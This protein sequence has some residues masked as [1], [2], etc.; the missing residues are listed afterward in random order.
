MLLHLMTVLVLCIALFRLV[1][2]PCPIELVRVTFEF[3]TIPLVV[4]PMA[5]VLGFLWCIEHVPPYKT[6]D[7][8]RRLEAGSP[9]WFPIH[10][11]LQPRKYLYN[12]AVSPW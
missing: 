12:R 10:G 9:V 4:C 1:T 7:V 3:P 11:T 8:R 2:C 6:V 5:Y